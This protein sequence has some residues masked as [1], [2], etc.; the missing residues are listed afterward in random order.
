MLITERRDGRYNCFSGKAIEM[1]LQKW[2][3]YM[4]IHQEMDQQ[5]LLDALK[6]KLSFLERGGYER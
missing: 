1:D 3:A 6:F 2:E 4:A 5:V